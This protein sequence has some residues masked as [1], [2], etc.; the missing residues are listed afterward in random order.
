M[1][2][3]LHSP[4]R[5]ATGKFIEDFVRKNGIKPHFVSHLEPEGK[6][7]SIKQVRELI[8]QTIYAQ[9]EPQLFVLYNFDTS[10]NEAQNAFLKTL[11]EHK[12]AD[13]FIMEA[14]QPYRLLP[15][16]VSRSQIV[17]LDQKES[18]LPDRNA[19]LASIFTGAIP[20]LNHPF[21]QVQK[22]ENQLEPFDHLITYLRTKLSANPRATAILKKVLTAR[23][24]V[25]EN[26]LSAQY[27]LDRLLIMIY[28]STRTQT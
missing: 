16:I 19:D 17:R 3:V 26:N 1:P 13:Q 27:A 18:K 15:T 9:S 8:K 14:Q 4:T 5:A 6:E 21:F 7:F 11:E 2:I 23:N 22:Y 12:A 10:S 24:G 25:R 28:K 20:P